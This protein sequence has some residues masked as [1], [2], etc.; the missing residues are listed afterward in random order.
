MA[1]LIGELN[2]VFEIFGILD[3]GMRTNIINHEGF[4]SLAVLGVL[5][6]TNMDVLEM[7]KRLASRMQAEGGIYL[8]TVMVKRIQTL[9]WW[10]HD[11]QKHGLPI[12]VADFTDQVM[13]KAAEMKGLLKSHPSVIWESS[14]LMTM[15]HMKM[16]FLTYWP[17]PMESF[18]NRSV[19]SFVHPDVVPEA[20][21]TTE[22]EC[23]MYQFPLTYNYFPFSWIIRLFIGNLKPS[24][25]I[26]LVGL[27]SNF[28]TR[29]R[30]VEQP[31]WLGQLIIMESDCS[32]Q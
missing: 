17:S 32:A 5:V 28:M 10:V 23:M 12:S 8:G 16:L 25:L 3:A 15:T 14:I 7:A 21:A 27:G 29:P 9:V 26:H 6:E 11:H 13:N 19:T 22:E 18:A 2:A 30:M 20:F 1:D 4:M 24:W 31:I